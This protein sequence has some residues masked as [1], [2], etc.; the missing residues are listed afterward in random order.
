MRPEYV[1]EEED[2]LLDEEGDDDAVNGRRVDV[3]V[4]LRRLVREVEVVAVD[5]VLHDLEENQY[6]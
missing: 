1:E 5:A 4:D 6:R 3:L 2:E